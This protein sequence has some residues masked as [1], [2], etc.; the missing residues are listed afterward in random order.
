[1]QKKLELRVFLDSNVI[2]SGLYSS[3]GPAGQI[4]DQMIEGRI[5]V[6]ISQQVVEETIRN[7]KIKIPAAIPTL[8]T[9]LENIRLEIIKDPAPGEIK[10]WSRAINFEDAPIFAAAVNAKPDYFITGDQH[11]YKNKELSTLSGLAII[12]PRQFLE[13]TNE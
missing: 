4:L 5:S 6:V 2:F 10:K 9:L 8:K 7:I 11:F 12:T 1:M 3:S 13:F